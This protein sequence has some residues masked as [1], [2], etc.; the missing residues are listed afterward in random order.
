MPKQK[1]ATAK[2]RTSTNTTVRIEPQRPPGEVR[3]QYADH[4]TLVTRDADVR[5]SFW[6][7]FGIGLPPDEASVPAYHLGS[8]VFTREGAEAFLTA[9]AG[10]LG[11]TVEPSEKGPAG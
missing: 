10:A 3:A 1:R 7:V 4:V 6:Q 8:Y 5:I 11:R 9:F 2:S